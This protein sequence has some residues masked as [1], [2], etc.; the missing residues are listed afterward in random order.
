MDVYVYVF[1]AMVVAEGE[2]CQHEDGLMHGVDLQ[3]AAGRW[4]P[5]STATNERVAGATTTTPGIE[6]R[7][8]AVLLCAKLWLPCWEGEPEGRGGCQL[9]GRET[10]RTR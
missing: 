3:D 2:R 1:G 8:Q 9:G 6:F 5:T 4:S 10:R 7:E